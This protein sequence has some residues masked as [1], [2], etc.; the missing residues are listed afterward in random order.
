LASK[1]KVSDSELIRFMYST[2]SHLSAYQLGFTASS[3][4]TSDK[5]VNFESQHVAYKNPKAS[6][7]VATHV[8][9]LFGVASSVDHASETQVE[10]WKRRISALAKI[11]NAS[12]LARRQNTSIFSTEFAQKLKEMNGDHAA[13]QKKTSVLMGNWKQKSTLVDLG[14]EK[15]LSTSAPEIIEIISRA[16]TAKISDVGGI[17]AWTS[18]T[19]EERNSRDILMMEG[20][21]LEL[22]EEAYNALSAA[23]QRELDLFVRAGCCM[24][25]ELNAVKGGNAAMTT[26]WAANDIPGPVL[27]ANRDNAATLEGLSSSNKATT[28]A[29]VC[30]FEVSGAG[31]VKTTS[32]AGAIFN[33]KDDKKGQ[34]DSHRIFF[35]A[36]K[37]G[38]ST[39]FPDTSSIRYQSYCRAAAELLAYLHHY[40]AFLL[41]IKDKKKDRRLN[42]MEQNLQNALHDIPTQTEL[43]VL[44][45]FGIFIMEPYIAYVRGSGLTETNVLNLGP[46]HTN[47]VDHIQ[48]L[49]DNPGLVLSP[50][51]A[52]EAEFLTQASWRENKAVTAIHSMVADLPHIRSVLVCFLEGSRETFT[53]FCEEFKEGGS[54]DTLTASERESAWMPGT[55]DVN[56]GALG[57]V[58]RI[59]RR[60]KPTQTMH[61]NIAQAKFS[62]NNT[63]QF[64]DNEFIAED[65]TFIMQEAGQQDESHL[66]QQRLSEIWEHDERVVAAR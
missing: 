50:D 4:G 58:V 64:M 19:N 20:V 34:Q 47:L 46:L 42:H 48:K 62:Y 54:I 52:D 10:G 27:L 41:A 12:P 61:Q 5:H 66:E 36:I 6:S 33:H 9:R 24:H 35:Q 13:D 55:N 26:W 28:S 2:F 18:M 29:E 63:Q 44:A 23:E 17:E 51:T 15:M 39:K 37:D 56:E 30:A 45:L 7:K 43:A 38:A 16:N 1:I 59:N 32:I 21:A 22:G 49:I 8:I 53:R 25:K 60:N 14:S 40:Q 31:G 65:H 3:D 11:Y 57:R